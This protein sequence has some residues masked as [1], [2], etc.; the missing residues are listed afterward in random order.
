MPSRDTFAACGALQ[1]DGRALVIHMEYYIGMPASLPNTPQ[2]KSR[3][4]LLD[5]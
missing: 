4:A 2:M 3:D 5:A 1:R